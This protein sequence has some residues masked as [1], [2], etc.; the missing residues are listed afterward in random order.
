MTRINLE[1]L[2]EAEEKIIT[3]ANEAKKRLAEKNPT[4]IDTVT[5]LQ[6]ELP[7]Q[8]AETLARLRKR[9]Q[10]LAGQA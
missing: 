6:R 7:Q 5:R 9:A 1:P 8:D 4:P 3:E 2:T 10:E